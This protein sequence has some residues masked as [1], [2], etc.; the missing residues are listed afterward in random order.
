MPLAIASY[1]RAPRPG[2]PLTL[3]EQQRDARVQR[4]L[5]TL[6]RTIFSRADDPYNRMFRLAG[7]EFGDFAGAAVRD[8]LETALEQVRRAGVFLA[9]DEFKGRTPIVRSGVHILTQPSSFDNPLVRGGLLTF[10]S[11]S[12]A[13]PLRTRESLELLSHRDAQTGVVWREFSLDGYAHVELR[14]ILPSLRA[15]ETCA[16]A[17]R[18]G[19]RVDR[20]FP[21]GIQSRENIHYRA[22]TRVIVAAATA[23]G[24][25]FPNPEYLP[26]NDFVPVARWIADERARGVATAVSGMMSSCVRVAAAAL[27]HGLDIR[28]TLFLGGGEALT[29]AKRAVIESAGAAIYPR[30]YITE[31]GNVGHACRHLNEGNSVHL[32]SEAVAAISHRRPAPLSGATVSSLL[33]TTLLPSA[34]RIL[35]NVEM[36]DA[37]TIE[38][39]ASCSCA[40]AFQRLGLRTVIHD[41]VSFGKLTGHG[42]TLVGTD[43]VRILEERLPAQFGGGVADF[44]LVE[45]EAG[46]QTEVH[47]RISPRVRASAEAVRQCFLAALR[48]ESGG[49]HAAALWTHAQAMQVVEA[50]PIVGRT[51]KI[52]PLHLLGTPLSRPGSAH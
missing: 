24:A 8:G 18:L 11:G 22:V 12:R 9:H 15:I 51:G 41:L 19:H 13:A 17:W 21:V 4:F 14:S 39:G 27:G 28:G 16:A 48:H 5:D 42:V 47:L 20:W 26:P 44:Q 6:E 50:E 10:S 1:V 45:L 33:L 36:D 43:V 52:L 32:Y 25:S 3:I 49:A 37:G 46:G 23:A 40:C 35:I 7:C 31:I 34:S 30:Y 29:A 38:D 2:D